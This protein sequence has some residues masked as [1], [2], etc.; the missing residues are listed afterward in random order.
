MR[1][2]MTAPE[3]PLLADLLV[4]SEDCANDKARE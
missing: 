3:R 4:G 1:G 2:T